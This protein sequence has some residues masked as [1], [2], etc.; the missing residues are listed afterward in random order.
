VIF[1]TS[2][3]PADAQFI[4]L[5]PEVLIFRTREAVLPGTVLGFNLVLEG[6]PMSLQAP[7][8]ACLV[9]EKE[10]KATYTFHIR[11]SLTDL[12]GSDR[13]LINL[14]IGKGRG[15]PRLVRAQPR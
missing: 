6:H 2:P 3:L 15:E 7:V 4:E 14:F 5:R 11:L 12:S 10:H 1:S 13:Q 8:E 9:V